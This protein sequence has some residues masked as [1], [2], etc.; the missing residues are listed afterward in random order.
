MRVILILFVLLGGLVGCGDAAAP[1]KKTPVSGDGP[2][3]TDG[4]SEAPKGPPKGRKG[5]QAAPLAP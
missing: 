2:S 4:P 1:A 3:S 5:K